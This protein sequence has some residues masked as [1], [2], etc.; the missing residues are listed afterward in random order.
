M[1]R[2]RVIPTLL[3]NSVGGLV[4]TIRFGRRI[5]I[6]D[7][8]N[9]VRIFNEKGVDELVLLDIDATRDG[10]EPNY[11]LIEEIAGEAF[12]PVGYGGG[13]KTVEQMARLFRCGLEKVVLCTA[14]IENPE[15][16]RA[17]ADRFGSQSIVGCL[18][19][20]RSLFRGPHVCL[21]SGR[22]RTSLS[23]VEAAR[24]LVESGVGEIIVN[25][26]DRDGTRRG[27]DIGLLGSITSEVDVPVVAC[28]GA[29]ELADIHLAV[30]RGGCAA[31]AAGSLFLFRNN[32]ILISY[33]SAD[34]LQQ[35]VFAKL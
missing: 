25:A 32:G 6:G 17:G 34:E 20:R 2:V 35:Q 18:D 28:G 3:L 12:M 4:K 31:A 19:V 15:V 33:P 1:R 30:E 8:I 29:G 23:P 22:Q 13:V 16:I 27:Y 21:L 11:T 14:A 24:K 10:R 26:V 5:Y 9:A 7:P